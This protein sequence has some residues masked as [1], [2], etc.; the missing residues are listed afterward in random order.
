[1]RKLALLSA[2]AI[3][4]LSVGTSNV[5]ADVN[6]FIDVDKFVDIDIV[7]AITKFKDV[8]IDV[9]IDV[10]PTKAAESLTV[11][12][13]RNQNN[14]ACE[15]CAEKSDQILGSINHN[16]GITSVNQSAG[17]QNN[18]GTAISIAFDD[19]GDQP[20]PPS[21]PRDPNTAF[22]ESQVAAAQ[23]MQFNTI[24]STNI[25]FREAVIAGSV[26]ENV[27]ITAFNQG[28]GN[29]N[30][31]ANAVS[32][33]VG[34][35]QGVALSDAALGQFNA[36]NSM[37]EFNVLKTA[38]LASSMNRNAGITMGNQSAGNFANQANIVSIAVTVGP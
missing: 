11:V 36:N 26:R 28:V 10:T 6:V 9:E 29:I 33:A 7:E 17:N 1:M 21:V 5:V 8:T 4:A 38:Q 2:S 3:A 24:N 14:T 27:G 19:I 20:P 13:Q 30:N 35:D 32:I 22:A 25:L 16:V 23:V 12:N 18:Q 37:T 34:G 15:N 31:Q